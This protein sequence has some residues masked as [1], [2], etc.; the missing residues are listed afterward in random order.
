MLIKN[1]DNIKN[2]TLITNANVISLKKSNFILRTDKIKIPGTNA[3][4]IND[5][6]GVKIGKLIRTIKSINSKLIKKYVDF[7]NIFLTLSETIIQLIV[8]KFY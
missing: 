1:P 4:K 2:A 7:L 6:I 5:N 3:K 8:Y